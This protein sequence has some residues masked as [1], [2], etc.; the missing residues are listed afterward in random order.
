MA[1]AES[2]VENAEVDSRQ[3]PDGDVISL[4]LYGILLTVDFYVL[5]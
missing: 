2:I 3:T 1:D 5:E 4:R